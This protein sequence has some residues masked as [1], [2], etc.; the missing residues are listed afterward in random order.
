MAV[1]TDLPEGKWENIE[2]W[3]FCIWQ[4]DSDSSRC[5]IQLW[6]FWLL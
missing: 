1:V 5:K 2:K 3:H 6:R 4:P